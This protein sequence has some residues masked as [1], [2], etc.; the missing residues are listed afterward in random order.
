MHI[1][2]TKKKVMVGDD[3]GLFLILSA[4]IS[5]CPFCESLFLAAMD[6]PLWKLPDWWWSAI[7][8]DIHQRGID[9][10]P[11]GSRC[12]GCKANMKRLNEGVKLTAIRHEERK[13][14]KDEVEGKMEAF[15]RKRRKLEKGKESS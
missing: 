10:S 6:L 1:Q 15:R 14:L 4:P 3:K 7:L 12:A 8:E 11:Y 2:I 5:Y 13:R 9:V